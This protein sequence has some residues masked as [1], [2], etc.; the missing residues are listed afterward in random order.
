VNFAIWADIS[1]PQSISF[2]TAVGVALSGWSAT[3]LSTAVGIYWGAIQMPL[4]TH[5][6]IVGSLAIVFF[7]GVLILLY[8]TSGTRLPIRQK[9]SEGEPK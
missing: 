3:F 8:F 1:T 6:R 5:L 9:L 7:L 2:N 4:E